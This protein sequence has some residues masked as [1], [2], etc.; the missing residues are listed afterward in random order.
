MNLRR[1]IKMLQ[2]NNPTFLR[3]PAAHKKRAYED[4]L[5]RARSI[6]ETSK[7]LNAPTNQIRKL[8]QIIRELQQELRR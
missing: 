7:R 5:E 6:L 1:C 2:R 8:E 3:N 4:L